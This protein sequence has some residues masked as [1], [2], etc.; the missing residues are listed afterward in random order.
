[1]LKLKDGVKVYLST[2]K[3]D[4]RKSIDGLSAIIV[5]YFEVQPTT[6]NIFIFFNKQKDKV[7]LLFWDR[8]GFVLYYKRLEKGKFRINGQEAADSVEIT[9]DQLGWLLAG[10]DFALMNEFSELNYCN[11]Y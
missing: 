6:G 4:M 8:N 10:L 5:D 2:N 11:Y 1:M 3:T 9:Q 7:K